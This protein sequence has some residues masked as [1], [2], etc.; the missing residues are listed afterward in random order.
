[1]GFKIIIEKFLTSNLISFFIKKF[2]NFNLNFININYS[3]ISPKTSAR[4][5]FGL[6]ERA[7]TKLIKKYIGDYNNILEIGGGIGITA[8]HCFNYNKNINKYY[9][10]EPYSVNLEIIKSQNF[11]FNKIRLIQ[12]CISNSNKELKNLD[13]SYTKPV[14][15]KYDKS[16]ILEKNLRTE[17]VQIL[18]EN[19]LLEEI[20]KIN[21]FL[22]IDCE[23]N[24]SLF[25]SQ[26]KKLFTNCLG[27]ICE[28]EEIEK[29]SVKNQIDLL[30]KNNFELKEKLGRV[31]FFFKKQQ[32]KVIY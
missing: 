29:Y 18:D 28:L 32:T 21:F 4:I 1:M 30:T 27:L 5:F 14:L 13:F 20:G 11:D 12:G 24:P 10:V 17:K 19:F 15:N 23:L 31:C 3:K 25:I 7:E 2:T 26:N 8:K 9:I 22:I 16:I 6:Y